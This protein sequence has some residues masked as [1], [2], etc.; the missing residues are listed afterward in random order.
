MFL[1]VEDGNETKAPP[2][3]TPPTSTLRKSEAA[4]EM[5]KKIKI[6]DVDF[7]IINGEGAGAYA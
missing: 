7:H 3:V 1:S 5:I 6:T 4:C 2:P